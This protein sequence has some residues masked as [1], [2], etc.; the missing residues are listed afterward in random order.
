MTLNDNIIENI[1]EMRLGVAM[2]R[3]VWR[4]FRLMNETL[5]YNANMV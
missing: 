5:C 4:S 1:M 3:Y 2:C